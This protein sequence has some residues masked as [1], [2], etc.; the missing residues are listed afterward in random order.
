MHCGPLT[1]MQLRNV[2]SFYW[3]TTFPQHLLC[4]YS[5]LA[6]IREFTPAKINVRTLSCLLMVI[7]QLIL[8]QLSFGDF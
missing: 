8:T 3:P 4:P 7:G 1:Q 2:M 5:I 6:K